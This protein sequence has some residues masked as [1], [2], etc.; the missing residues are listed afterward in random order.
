MN[1]LR[2]RVIFN[3]ALGVMTAVS[4]LAKIHQPNKDD[5]VIE[6]VNTISSVFNLQKL[7]WLTSLVLGNILWVSS[8]D[9]NIV[10]DANAPG[11]QRP[12]IIESANGTPQ[13]NIHTPSASGVSHNKYSQFDVNQK[14]LF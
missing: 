14:G 1:K 2:Y 6:G 11:N 7:V 5:A 3:Q 12:I 10:A 13:V 8:V 4:E 9:A